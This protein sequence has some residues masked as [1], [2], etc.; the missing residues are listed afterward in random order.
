MAESLGQTATVKSEMLCVGH[1]SVIAAFLV[2][3][4]QRLVARIFNQKKS[5][6]KRH[7]TLARN[8]AKY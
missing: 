8:F 6:K 4:I 1:S 3:D 5:I 7:Y 2:Y